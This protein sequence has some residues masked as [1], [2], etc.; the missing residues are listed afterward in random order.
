M[1]GTD[2]FGRV[3]G[4]FL[5]ADKDFF[6]GQLDGD[7]VFERGGFAR[8]IFDCGKRAQIVG[9]ESNVHHTVIVS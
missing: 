3:F 8:Q 2:V 1:D 9:S 4:R 5:G 6:Q 7:R